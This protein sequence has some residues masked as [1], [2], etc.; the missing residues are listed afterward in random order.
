MSE[1]GQLYDLLTTRPQ[2]LGALAKKGGVSLNYAREYYE[3]LRER[4]H[5][6]REVKV[7]GKTRRK[8]WFYTLPNG[9]KVDV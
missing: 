2:A 6:E 5:V 9:S 7:I 8:I 4:G 3:V 1:N